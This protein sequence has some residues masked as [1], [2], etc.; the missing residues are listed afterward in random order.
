MREPRVGSPEIRREGRKE[1]RKGS[2]KLEIGIHASEITFPFLERAIKPFNGYSK[3]KRINIQIYFPE[4]ESWKLERLQR[5]RNFQ[6]SRSLSTNLTNGVNFPS[7]RRRRRSSLV[8]RRGAGWE[9]D[10]ETDRPLGRRRSSRRREEVAESSRAVFSRIPREQVTR[11]RFLLGDCTKFR[12]AF[13]NYLLQAIGKLAVTR[14]G[15]RIERKQW[16]H[17]LYLNRRLLPILSI[18]FSRAV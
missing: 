14:H 8:F 15:F 13:A 1:S 9:R 2:K 6:S 16:D 7:R 4:L 11:H 17:R 12:Q 5:R 18:S 10:V 3:R